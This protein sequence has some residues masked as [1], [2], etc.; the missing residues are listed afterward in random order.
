MATNFHSDLPNNQIHFPKDFSLAN[1]SSVLSK[2]SSGNL[3]WNSV[4]F[5][6]ST[7]ITCGADSGGQ[8][9]NR[10]FHIF[11]DKDNALEVHFDVTGDTTAFVPTAGY[12]QV[13]VN[14]TANDTAITIAAAIKTVLDGSPGGFSFTTSVDGHGKV[15]FSGMRNSAD[16]QNQDTDYTFVNTKTYSGSQYLNADSNGKMSWVGL[17]FEKEFKFNSPEIRT[18][19]IHTMGDSRLF[20]SMAIDTGS[21]TPAWHAM[22]ALKAC[23]YHAHAGDSFGKYCG[24]IAGMGKIRVGLYV[25]QS[26]C[27]VSGGNTTDNG[28]LLVD[29]PMITLGGNRKTFCFDLTHTHS[30][31]ENDLIIPFVQEMAGEP[32]TF[33]ATGRILINREK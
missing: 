24:V 30:F 10:R 31:T 3:D 6:L 29:T 18:G 1:N 22:D 2:N 27:Y 26:P 20:D 8:T 7:T 15:T 33:S 11:Y 23:V 5:D 17:P 12:T 13:T 16:T 9:H 32:L 4:P 28:T 25:Y 21:I 19:N 14:I